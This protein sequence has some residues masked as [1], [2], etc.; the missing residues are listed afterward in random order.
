M[1]NVQGIELLL[2]CAQRRRVGISISGAAVVSLPSIISTL[3]AALENS[4]ASRAYFSQ[5]VRSALARLVAAWQHR[6]RTDER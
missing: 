5:S 1:S 2:G 6:R 4:L 3:K